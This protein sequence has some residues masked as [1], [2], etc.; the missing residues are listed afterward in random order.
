MFVITSKTNMTDELKSVYETNVTELEKDGN[1]FNHFLS[2]KTTT[3]A[4]IDLTENFD[5][6]FVFNEK[7]NQYILTI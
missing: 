5:T 6:P 2:I 4:I 1:Y 3:E 7:T